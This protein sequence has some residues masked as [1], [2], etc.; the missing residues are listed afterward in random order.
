MYLLR[1]ALN[2]RGFEM[3]KSQR[4][5]QYRTT[6]V[7]IPPFPPSRW[8]PKPPMA[9]PHWPRLLRRLLGWRWAVERTYL[10]PER[11]FWS[12]ASGRGTFWNLTPT[13]C[14]LLPAST[15][16]RP[17]RPSRQ[18]VCVPLA[19]LMGRAVVR[20]SFGATINRYWV[21]LVG[22]AA[23]AAATG[24]GPGRG[25]GMAPLIVSARSLEVLR[26][27]APEVLLRLHVRP[28]VHR[29]TSSLR[30]YSIQPDRLWLDRRMS[31]LLPNLLSRGGRRARAVASR[32]ATIQD[33]EQTDGGEGARCDAAIVFVVCWRSK[34]SCQLLQCNRT[35]LYTV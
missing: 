28:V 11:S 33:G 23:A 22:T 9:P 29:C 20:G 13:G 7:P 24:L 10:T 1:G 30:P 12:T 16:A 25:R 17:R 34:D 26:V 27:R 6:I 32:R 4:L 21:I 5:I 18:T 31:T 19:Y 14:R 2:F 3:L 35:T 8:H 15:A